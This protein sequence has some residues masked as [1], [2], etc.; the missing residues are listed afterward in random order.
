SERIP[1][2]AGIV[3]LRYKSCPEMAGQDQQCLHR[4]RQGFIE[5]K[6]A[7]YNR[8]RGLISEFGVIAPQSTDALRHMVSEQKSSLPLQVQ[9][10]VNDLL[11]HIDRIEDNITE[12][13]RI[14]SRMAKT[15]HR[16]QR[17][18]ELKGIGPT[19]ACAL[20]TSIGNAHDFKNGRQLAAWLGL[21]PSQYSSGGKSKLGR[22]TKAGDSYLRTL[23]VQGA[24][25]V[26]IGAEKRTDLF[27]RWVCSLVDR[28]GYWRAVVA[29]AAKNA[30]LCWASLHYGDDFRL[31]SAS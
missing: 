20:V 24:R 27:S 26:L 23:L 31:Y 19:T 18:M 17:L 5:E 16:S 4:I 6:T 7:T 28:R 10:C 8:L 21:T 3:N 14:L 29:I 2:A 22:I 30:R 11:E 9:Q 25:S 13:D 1:A 15:D 12:Y